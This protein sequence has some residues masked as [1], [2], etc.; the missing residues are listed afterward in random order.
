MQARSP[1]GGC[2]SLGGRPTHRRNED[3]PRGGS[4]LPLSRTGTCARGGRVGLT[5]P[6]PGV[7]VGRKSAIDDPSWT[8]SDL[9][10]PWRDLAA[11]ACTH[12]DRLTQVSTQRGRAQF[13]GVAR[14]DG[15]LP[16]QQA[17]DCSSSVRWVRLWGGGLSR[18]SARAR[19]QTHPNLQTPKGDRGSRCPAAQRYTW[20]QG[21]SVSLAR[22]ACNGRT[23]G[24][25]RTCGGGDLRRAERRWRGDPLA[26]PGGF[27][28]RHAQGLGR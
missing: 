4:T 5:P 3:D 13:G 21:L 23:R 20:Q 19:R 11:L 1:N 2:Y 16:R 10:K 26:S 28:R 22:L 8:Q 15:V 12:W 9:L 6:S 24:Q 14:G 27:A 7:R 25:V 18:A 17:G